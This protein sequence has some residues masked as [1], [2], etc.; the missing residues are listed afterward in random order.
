MLV[1]HVRHIV[2]LP[3]YTPEELSSVGLIS[4]LYQSE[5]PPIKCSF[6]LKKQ[7]DN[8]LTVTCYLQFCV[9][10]PSFITCGKRNFSPRHDVLTYTEAYSFFNPMGICDYSGS[11]VVVA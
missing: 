5:I 2:F 4:M 3:T 6:S 11:N 7:R 1:I 10:N 8:L 9:M